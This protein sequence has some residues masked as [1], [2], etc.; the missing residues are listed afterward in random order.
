MSKRIALLAIM[1]LDAAHAESPWHKWARR[2][3][4]AAACAASAVDGYQSATRIDGS[5]F[6][7]AN[8]MLRSSNG[9]VNI[10]RMVSLKLGMCAAPVIMGE[11]THNDWMK[12]DA[13]VGAAA[14]VGAFS[15]IDLHN[16]AVFNSQQ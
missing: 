14:S 3:V 6:V 1:I 10:G 13:F 15:W 8:P 16:R 11:F 2:A 12:R 4:T 5:Q 9:S 7:E